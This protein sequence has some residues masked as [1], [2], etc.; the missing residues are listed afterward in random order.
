MARQEKFKQKI[1]SAL[2]LPLSPAL[3]TVYMHYASTKSSLLAG[4]P[5]QSKPARFSWYQQDH[6]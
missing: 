4:I 3:S 5:A 6:S 2:W 1:F